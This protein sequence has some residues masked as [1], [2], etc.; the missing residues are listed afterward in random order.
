MF[1]NICWAFSGSDVLSEEK[2]D[3]I[4]EKGLSAHE[5]VA[6]HQLENLKKSE[7]DNIRASRICLLYT[8]PSPRDSDSSRMPSSA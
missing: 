7:D 1:R 4:M 6:T 5:Q 2:V 8:S 3:Y